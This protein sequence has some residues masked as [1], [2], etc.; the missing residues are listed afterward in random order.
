MKI[1]SSKIKDYAKSLGID[2]VGITSAELFNN[3]E[4]SDYTSIIVALFP[5]YTG[6][7]GGANLSRYTYGK[8]YHIVAKEYL[9]KIA[10]HFGIKN[11]EIYADIGPSIDRKLAINAGLC[12]RGKNTMAINE[13]YG[14]YFFIGYIVCN[15]MLE[16]DTPVTK[17]CM[18]CKKCI[19]ACPGGAINDDFTIDLDKCASH[20]SQKKGELTAYETSLIKKTGL[21]F[22]CD[23]C[24]AVCP[25]NKDI[26]I[27]PI[28]EFKENIISSLGI[29]DI[30]K[31]SNK[32]FK[33]KYGDRAF[34]WRGKNVILRNL[35]NLD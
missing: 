12:F 28:H 3:A 29:S 13:K 10:E 7:I 22:G 4:N 8:D 9:S 32:E 23:I 6:E 33:E 31:L 24:Q 30:E 26:A 18:D 5:Y 21:C 35:K 25:H 11:Y 17:T 14:S 16:F 27:T 34:S 2:M 1:T 19:N 15:E 20:I